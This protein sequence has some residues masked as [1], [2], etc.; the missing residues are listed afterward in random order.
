LRLF[1]DA[2][3]NPGA[4]VELA[5]IDRDAR[6]QQVRLIDVRR[7]AVVLLEIGGQRLR[8]RLVAA[9]QRLPD[10]RVLRARLEPETVRAIAPPEPAPRDETADG[11]A[12]ENPG[13]VLLDPALEPFPLF[14][15]GH[16]LV[17]NSLLALGERALDARRQLR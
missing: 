2:L 1:H 12:A 7:G 3:Q 10:L 8:L 15:F 16:V 4:L 17:H 9:V 13:T 6:E 5:R 14:F 11:D